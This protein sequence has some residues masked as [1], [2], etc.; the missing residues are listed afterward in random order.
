M[1]RGRAPSRDACLA[2]DLAQC[3]GGAHQFVLPTLCVVREGGSGM[4]VVL[5]K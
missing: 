3:W 4:Y 1:R 2:V 5:Y